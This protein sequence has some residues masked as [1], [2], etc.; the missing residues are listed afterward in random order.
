MW[1]RSDFRRFSP[2]HERAPESTMA[3]GVTIGQIATKLRSEADHA[4]EVT[5][6]IAVDVTNNTQDAIEVNV[7]VQA[8]DDDG[9]EL[10][11]MTL[12]GL[13]GPGETKRLSDQGYMPERDY[14][15]IAKWQVEEA[16]IS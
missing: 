11:D 16:R 3:A 15:A 8:V 1:I 5:F 13:L 9:F 14:R 10:H 4:G 7:A 6:A 2:S 12:F